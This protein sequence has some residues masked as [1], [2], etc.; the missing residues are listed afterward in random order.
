[1]EGSRAVKRSTA[2][3]PIRGVAP[4][5]YEG[6]QTPRWSVKLYTDHE[7]I[8]ERG[9][10]TPKTL[11]KDHKHFDAWRKFFMPVLVKPSRAGQHHDPL[12]RL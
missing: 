7:V 8:R 3:H 1:M 11:V 2:H 4:S 12:E 5:D 6:P 10:K 9:Y